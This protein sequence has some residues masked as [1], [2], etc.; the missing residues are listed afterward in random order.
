M[1]SISIL[2]V[3]DEASFALELEMMIVKLGYQYLGN[4]Q[5]SSEALRAID[6][7]EPDLIILDINIQGELDGISFAEKIQT[8]NIPII[9]ITSFESDDYF[10]RAHK[11][12]PAGY[13]VKPFHIHTL[14]SVIEKAPINKLNLESQK[15][16]KKSLILK[17]NNTLHKVP[18]DEI[19][20]IEVDGNYCYF[21]TKEKKFVLKVSLKRV[22]K[23]IDQEDIFLKVHR[24]FVVHKSCIKNFN[25]K[26]SYIQIAGNKIT[27]GRQYRN[28]VLEILKRFKT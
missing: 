21:I 12:C 23:Q 16:D 20:Y 26:D 28:L 1:S 14:R 7:K 11:I 10:E 13:L 4:P 2:I 6:A 22:L 8:R 15:E 25:S 27:V 3:E 18:F 17:S 9:F 5:T 24:K 19:Y